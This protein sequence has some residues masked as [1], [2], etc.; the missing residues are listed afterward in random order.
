M[1]S[2]RN[3]TRSGVGT[4]RRT[5]QQHSHN[6]HDHDRPSYQDR[7]PNPERSQQPHG[8]TE[9]HQSSGVINIA[10]LKSKKIVELTRIAKSLGKI[11]R[12]HV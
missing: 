11:G 10:E 3:S 8:Q 1:R 9:M 6:S 5:S 7:S 4:P 12:A 2:P